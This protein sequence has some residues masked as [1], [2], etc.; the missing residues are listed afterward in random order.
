MAKIAVT[1]AATLSLLCAIAALI[2]GVRSYW[3]P[4]N[5]GWMR[6]FR[7]G[8]SISTTNSFC[9]TPWN[10]KFSLNVGRVRTDGYTTLQ[11][12]QSESEFVWRAMPSGPGLRY[13]AQNRFGFG[14][15]NNDMTSNGAFY[16]FSRS[17]TFPAWFAVMLF[18]ILPLI[19]F[20]RFRRA[21][22]RESGIKQGL[23][24]VFGYD[25]R[26]TPARCPE[27]GAQPG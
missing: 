13:P 26:A 17:I 8:G 22:R 15:D 16:Q 1:I 14:Y 20:L 11:V 7:D 10:G 18:S 24:P 25:L 19:W 21:R 6:S 27:C 5:I 9:I 12:G 23:C 2:L 3:R 4:E